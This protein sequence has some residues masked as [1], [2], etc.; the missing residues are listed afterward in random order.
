MPEPF[1]ENSSPGW[2]FDN[3]YN[4]AH[5][6]GGDKATCPAPAKSLPATG[7]KTIQKGFKQEFVHF[8][9]HGNTPTRIP[10]Q[11]VCITMPH[12]VSSGGSKVKREEDESDYEARIIAA[13]LATAA[14]D[15]ATNDDAAL[16]KRTPLAA[17]PMMGMM[18]DGGM[19]GMSTFMP[20]INT[21]ID[22]GSKL[23]VAFLQYLT[24]REKDQAEAKKADPLAGAKDSTQAAV[25]P[26]AAST[27]SPIDKASALTPATSS[28]D[29]SSV[30]SPGASGI[31]GAAATGTPG[32][33][34]SS[35]ITDTASSD[36]TS[37]KADADSPST[38]GGGL[39]E[40]G[41]SGDTGSE[42]TGP[43]EAGDSGS[44][45]AKSSLADDVV[46]SSAAKSM[47]SGQKSVG[48]A[49]DSSAPDDAD[50]LS[51]TSIKASLPQA[52]PSA[53]SAKVGG[54][55]LDSSAIGGSTDVG[56]A[57]GG[58]GG[59][60]P[61]AG[62]SGSAASSLGIK[63][64]SKREATPHPVRHSDPASTGSSSKCG[65]SAVQCKKLIER[66]IPYCVT[67]KLAPNAPPHTHDDDD[68]DA[69]LSSK[70]VG[71]MIRVMARHCLRKCPGFAG[72]A[73]SDHDF[74]SKTEKCA[75]DTKLF[76]KSHAHSAKP[77]H[78]HATTSENAFESKHPKP[79]HASEPKQASKRPPAPDAAKD[80]GRPMFKRAVTP[81]RQPEQCR[82]GYEAVFRNALQPV[83]AY[84]GQLFGSVVS[85]PGS[86]LHWGLVRNVAQCQRACDETQGCV[87]INVY[88]QTFSLD[89]PTIRLV[90]RDVDDEVMLRKQFA[91][92]PEAKKNSF[93]EGHL[94]C[95]LY[96]R[97]FRGCQATHRSGE[98][99]VFF[100]K[101]IGYCKSDKCNPAT[102]SFH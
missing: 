13:S 101:S 57:M 84:Q 17:A 66:S 15:D 96:S 90:N 18:G 32:G 98:N 34:D 45:L 56:S 3:V 99:P 28:A 65:G 7:S 16:S 31:D 24:Q 5:W 68:P 25:D 11:S 76:N 54:S 100:E 88:Q 93:V 64:K 20:L 78:R 12:K 40:K 102:Q 21:G 30:S 41:S 14:E 51:G 73:K 92:K 37:P 35:G 91:G 82:G 9:Q 26:L 86:F 55:T 50:D 63:S 74:K 69:V 44:R 2:T 85:D 71:T 70:M 39:T 52:G 4:V 67:H 43:S 10:D 19:S 49:K 38:V 79:E 89:H 61:K 48:S 75:H 42:D 29:G 80:E 87:F 33:A 77:A 6:D 27:A 36:T 47:S 46:G 59:D 53:S 83:S 95:A 60:S 8:C 22:A 23:G 62:T 72:L 94:T 81:A 1:L 97:C 58:S